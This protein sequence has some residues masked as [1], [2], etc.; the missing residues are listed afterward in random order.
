MIMFRNYFGLSVIVPQKK[1]VY[2]SIYKS[3]V[4]ILQLCSK[5]SFSSEGK[6]DNMFGDINTSTKMN[7]KRLINFRLIFSKK[8][9]LKHMTLNNFCYGL[10][11]IFITFLIRYSDIFTVILIGLGVPVQEGLC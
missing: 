6:G 10:F 5:R 4:V 3:D 7:N 2:V 9:L 11:V 8:N 1:R